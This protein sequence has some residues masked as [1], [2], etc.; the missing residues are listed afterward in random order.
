MFNGKI[1]ILMGKSELLMGKSPF[2]MGKTQFLMGKTT[3]NHIYID[4][5]CDLP[6]RNGP[7]CPARMGAASAQ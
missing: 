7:G 2:L 1:T 4:L 3:I 5:H 6:C